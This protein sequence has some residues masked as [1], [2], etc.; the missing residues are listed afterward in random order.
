MPPHERYRL[1]NRLR[2]ISKPLNA[3]SLLGDNHLIE[4]AQK[5]GR[6][7]LSSRPRAGTAR[8]EGSMGLRSQHFELPIDPSTRCARSG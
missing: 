5:P 4:A 6:H 1:S 2:Q 8:V 3:L 7:C